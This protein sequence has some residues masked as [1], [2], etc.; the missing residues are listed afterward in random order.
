MVHKEYSDSVH[1]SPGFYEG[2]AD[3]DFRYVSKR[4]YIVLLPSFRSI[5]HIQSSQKFLTYRVSNLPV[6]R[7]NNRKTRTNVRK[8][9]ELLNN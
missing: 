8:R 7:R 5:I 1:H 3:L 9:Y 2:L 4:N 6:R